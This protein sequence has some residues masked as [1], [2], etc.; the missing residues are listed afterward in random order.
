M[1]DTTCLLA[2]VQ[3]ADSFFPSGMFTHSL[4]LEQLVRERTITSP[5]DV[6][7]LARAVL[8]RSVSTSDAVAAARAVRATGDLP[9]LIEV[10]RELF[11]MKASAE[12]RRATT[13]TGRRLLEEVAAHHSEPILLRFLEEVRAERTPGTHAVAFGVVAATFGATPEV[14]AALVMQ[15]TVSAILQA[16]LRLLPVS[17]RDVQSALHHLRPHIAE[18]AQ[19]AAEPARPLESFH[20]VQDIASTRHETSPVRM[21]AS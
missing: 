21:F 13:D 8:E 7:S 17:H 9:A 2:L 5:E 19:R 20:P 10:D 11:A 1:S 18:L 14:A 3:I 16:A 15:G 4:G 6:A 12:L